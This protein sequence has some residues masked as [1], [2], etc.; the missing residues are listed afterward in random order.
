MFWFLLSIKGD[1]VSEE[2]EGL[3]EGDKRLRFHWEEPVKHV[4][5]EKE[6][7]GVMPQTWVYFS[8]RSATIQSVQVYQRGSDTEDRTNTVR[9]D[10]VVILK[11][12]L[13]MHRSCTRALKCPDTKNWLHSVCEQRKK[14]RQQRAEWSY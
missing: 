13:G 4:I 6:E 9:W 14:H 2:E 3:Y 7:V 10:S 11:A 12:F 5:W 8:N 1:R